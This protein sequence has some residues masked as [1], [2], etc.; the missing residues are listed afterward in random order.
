MPILPLTAPLCYIR[1][2]PCPG[3]PALSIAGGIPL[4]E[5]IYWVG[6]KVCSESPLNKLFGQPNT[7]R[8]TLKFNT[9][10]V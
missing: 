2:F 1:V 6:Q 10:C 9:F 8:T 7:L 3:R 4:Y 5:Q